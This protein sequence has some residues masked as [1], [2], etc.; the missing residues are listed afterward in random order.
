[1]NAITKHFLTECLFIKRLV[2]ITLKNG[3][4]SCKA[5]A[6]VQSGLHSTRLSEEIRQGQGLFNHRQ[7]C[8]C[9]IDVILIP[10]DLVGNDVARTGRDCK[11]L[12]VTSGWH[13]ASDR[14]HQ[15]N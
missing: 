4:A 14:I 8:L 7:M 15:R 13:P 1:M 3:S 12:T 6:A 9:Q 5:G 10:F 2:V 11:S